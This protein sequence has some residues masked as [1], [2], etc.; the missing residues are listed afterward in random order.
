M[1]RI[2]LDL[3]GIVLQL[4]SSGIAISR[5]KEVLSEARAL[6][7]EKPITAKNKL[8]E[9]LTTAP[10]DVDARLQ[11]VSWER[12]TKRPL[13]AYASLDEELA[14]TTNLIDRQAL[15]ARGVAYAFEDSSYDIAKTY[16][17]AARQDR[18]I[19]PA[20]DLL[21]DKRVRNI[22]SD[23]E[24]LYNIGKVNEATTLVKKVYSFDSK[25]PDAASQLGAWYLEQKDYRSALFAYKDCI[26]SGKGSA[27]QQ[28]F[29]N[30]R[31]GDCY[32]ELGKKKLAATYYQAALAIDLEFV[33][34]KNAL[35]KL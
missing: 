25:N 18:A 16:I 12:E 6:F 2:Q 31:I 20:I 22:V 3:G 30:F 4:D 33:N 35:K 19:A 17:T 10:S 28:K 24:K 23:A 13:A 8:R 14:A 34:A 11:L 7:R 27:R 26:D 15:F 21:V 5:Q 29:A 9:Y 1:R 32:R